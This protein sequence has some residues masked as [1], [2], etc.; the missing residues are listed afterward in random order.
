MKSK[1]LTATGL[2]LGVVLLLAVNIFSNT[3]FTSVR[4]DLTQNKLYTLSEG[5]R[6]VLSALDEPI[7]LRLFL[8]RALLTRLPSTNSY[9]KRV[10][11][12]LQEYQRA[13]GGKLL[14]NV[15]DAEPFS[16]EED[17]AVGHGL[18]GIP[19]DEESIF[20][21]GLAATDS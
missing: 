9:A 8:S 2:A 4:L 11:D 1:W 5:T 20:Y 21:F 10:Q 15:V 12:L 14:V 17:R 3:A 7:T 19:L 6:N 13:A 16:E 18:H